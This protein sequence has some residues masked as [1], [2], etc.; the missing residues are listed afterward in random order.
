MNPNALAQ[1]IAHILYDKKALDIVVLNV[2]HL[3]VITD[4][5]VIASG[6]S[7]LQVKALA[8]DV[9]DAMAMEGIS[10]R[11]REG[12]GEGRWIVL[13]FGTVLVHIFH[14]EDRQFY[15][16]ERLWEDGENRVA[17]P[18]MDEEKDS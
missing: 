3:T 4:Y 17:L 1:R 9:D 16:L 18:F 7:S 6:R 2:S 8:D 10:L 14:P 13:D 15:H 5:M 11:A 12:A